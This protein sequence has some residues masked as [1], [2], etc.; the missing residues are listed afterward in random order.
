MGDISN[1]NATVPEPQ[2]CRTDFVPSV[3]VVNPLVRQLGNQAYGPW[4]YNGMTEVSENWALPTPQHRSFLF[5]QYFSSGCVS[6]YCNSQSQCPGSK[7]A[8]VMLGSP[9]NQMFQPNPVFADQLPGSC[10]QGKSLQNTSL[11]WMTVAGGQRAGF[12]TAEAATCS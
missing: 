2:S 11:G 6:L 7:P 5:P 12:Q 3:T 1:L 8:Q 9:M 10:F 4:H